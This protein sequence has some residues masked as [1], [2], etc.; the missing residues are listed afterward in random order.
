V[1]RQEQRVAGSA[2]QRKG[3]GARRS[4]RDAVL[5]AAARQLNARGVSQTSLSEIAAELGVSRAALYYYVEDR[6]D[7]VFQC[8]RRACEA[9]ARDL[10][11]AA[12]LAGDGLA[13]LL[14]FV[15]LALDAERPEP[16][17]LAE[18]GAL[19]SP[20]RETIEALQ[21]GNVAQLVDLLEAGLADGSI[22]PCDPIIVAQAIVGIVSWIPLVPRWTGEAEA[23]FRT[24][25]RNGAR[26]LLRHGVA[27]DPNT[28][29]GYQ[30]LDLSRLRAP[31]GNVFDRD[32]AA[33]MKLEELLRA[34]SRLFNK[35]GVEATSID[36]IAAEVGATKGVVYHYL[37][38]K[39]DLVARCFRR[40]FTLSDRILA[41]VELHPGTA[42]Q[43]NLAAVELLVRM[44]LDDEFCPLAPLAGVE[45]LPA[46]ARQE[47]M[48]RVRALE[49]GYPDVAREGL[50]DG[51][52]RD[53][54]LTAVAE[55]MAGAFGWLHKWWRP[56]LA[57]A[58][59]I[60][61]EHVRLLAGG[62]AAR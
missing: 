4:K 38:D 21:R 57:P 2:E 31:R 12:K 11:A 8:Y 9:M 7:L 34:A 43:R 36:E 5:D 41:A 44:N 62:L 58:D 29:L 42:M 37:A 33:A 46:D 17:A 23:G 27:T 10:D 3:E 35:K 45:A 14:A 22:R 28:A 49:Q 16:A 50:A 19:G 55:C 39:P 26:T 60:V 54:D 32:A 53:V 56:E 13:R 61:R 30:P 40:A 25:A 51:S 18:V 6:E 20:N 47:I 1:R 59:R 15:D 48:A 24:R 52:V